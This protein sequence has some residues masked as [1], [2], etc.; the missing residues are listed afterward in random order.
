MHGILYKFRVEYGKT[1]FRSGERC[2][3]FDNL[4]CKL[5][6]SYK[7]T[8]TTRTKAWNKGYGAEKLAL[9]VYLL[10]EEEAAREARKKENLSR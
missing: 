2:K 9:L 4:V 8:D 5:K 7:L 6:A 1:Y 3:Q 10:W